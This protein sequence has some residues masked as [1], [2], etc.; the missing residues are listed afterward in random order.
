MAY[1]HDEKFALW[2]GNITNIGLS[3]KESYLLTVEFKYIT[4]LPYPPDQ[5]LKLFALWYII[6]NTKVWKKSYLHTFYD[7][8]LT[9]PAV[10]GPGVHTPCVVSHACSSCFG[11][12]STVLCLC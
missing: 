9:Q 3:N 1:L 2:E 6:Q 4:T 5:W 12:L 11:D 8:C 7:D 10:I